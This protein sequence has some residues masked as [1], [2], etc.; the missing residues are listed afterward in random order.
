MK[1]FFFVNN[2]LYSLLI[3]GQ[4][5]YSELQDNVMMS[6]GNGKLIRIQLHLR[7]N[8]TKF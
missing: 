2:L 7:L 3:F 5:R 6:I 4:Q 8:S 1:H